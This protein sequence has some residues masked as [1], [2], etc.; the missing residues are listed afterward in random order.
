MNI[1]K[2]ELQ[3]IRS[4]EQQSIQ[5]P[6]G[7]I[8][9]H[10][11][12]GAGKTSLVMGLFG[13]L[14][15]S[16]I[17]N[18]GNNSF[19]LD[20]FV[21][22]GGNKGTV[23][24][25]FEVSGVEYEVEWE[26]YTTSTPNDATLRSPEFDSPVSGITDVKKQIQDILGMDEEDFANSVYVKQ[27]EV[28]RLIEASDRA[29]MIDGLLGLDKLDENIETMKMARRGAGRVQTRNEDQADGY[30]DDLQE[31]FD[32]DKAEFNAEITEIDSKIANVE[33]DIDEV[34]QYINELKNAQARLESRIKD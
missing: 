5:F 29:E 28:D 18:V 34:E 20:E 25:V 8:L 24:L 17:R 30:R 14:F 7:T 15:L 2:L 1:K 12:N 32:R 10:G 16:E 22:R 31:D 23:E 26:L 6:E 21:R 9:I 4:Y 19:S 33:A 3:N 13:G 27:G 11:D